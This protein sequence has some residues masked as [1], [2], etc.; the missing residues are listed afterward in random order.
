MEAAPAARVPDCPGQ[1]Q[2]THLLQPQTPACRGLWHLA[3]K[4]GLIR[5]HG[6]IDHR[7]RAAIGL[8]WGFRHPA[9]AGDLFA[10]SL[11]EDT[12]H[13]T[14]SSQQRQSHRMPGPARLGPDRVQTLLARK[15][16][17]RI[18]LIPY[19]VIRSDWD[20]RALELSESLGWRPS[21]SISSMTRWTRSTM[22]TPS[23]SAAATPGA[24]TSCCT[25]TAWWCPSSAP[26]ASGRALC[27]LERRLQRGDP[28]IR[29]TNDMPVC[30]AAV[31][32]A[33]GL[34]PLQINPTIWM[35]AS[36]ATWGDPR[37]APG[38]VLRHQPERTR[39][40]PARGESAADQR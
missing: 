37:R 6:A 30:S 27:G 35:P 14:A 34:F 20:A 11:I 12:L 26:C 38:R 40:S 23:S 5:V 33:L 15:Q 7:T 25:K 8:E 4:N 36:A 16:V 21:A 3:V 18:L 19:A 31:L 22:L 17:K 24:S 39:G 1:R 10:L 29:T 2:L 32:P 28:S 9:R 13:G